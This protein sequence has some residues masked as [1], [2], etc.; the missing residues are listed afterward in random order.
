MRQCCRFSACEAA[1]IGAAAFGAGI[2]LSL[3]V[4]CGILFGVCGTVFFVT[5]AA[6]VLK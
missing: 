3:F 6:C 4:P 2:V 5:G 1:V